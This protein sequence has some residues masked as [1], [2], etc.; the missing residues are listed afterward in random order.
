MPI[1]ASNISKFVRKAVGA[2]IYISLIIFVNRRMQEFTQ[3][4][5]R[6]FKGK[7]IQ[8]G[9][10]INF[11]IKLSFKIKVG[12]Y[13]VKLIFPDFIQYNLFINVT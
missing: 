8:K 11:P 5:A 3:W 13:P 2:S 1:I 7:I 6:F 10:N 9:K 12:F 4:D